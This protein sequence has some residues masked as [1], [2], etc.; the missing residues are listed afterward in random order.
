MV[1]AF[2]M[3]ERA[4][5][6]KEIIR[7]FTRIALVALHDLPKYTIHFVNDLVNMI[8]HDAETGHPVIPIIDPVNGICNNF[9][10]SI[11]SKVQWARLWVIKQAI[12]FP[13][14]ELVCFS[15]S[16]FDFRAR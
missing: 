6:P 3:P 14:M 5:K 4:P 7:S 15:N 11:I 10:D 8:G 2:M 9:G 1:K 13:E 16:L 12:E